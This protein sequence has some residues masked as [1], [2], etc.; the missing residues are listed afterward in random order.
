MENKK[1]FRELLT[2]GKIVTTQEGDVFCV[3]GVTERYAILVPLEITEDGKVVPVA[4]VVTYDI[5][6]DGDE[7]APILDIVIPTGGADHEE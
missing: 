7:T 6:V 1:T 3:Y 4:D 2:V 5:T